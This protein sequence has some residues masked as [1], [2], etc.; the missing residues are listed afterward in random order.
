MTVVALDFETANE[1]R[2]SA[3]AVGL[4]WI[5]DG[6]VVRRASRLIRPP[7]LRF[8]PGNIRVH[9]ILPAD[10]RA[11]PGFGDVMAEFLPD[12]TDGLILAHNASFDIG[13]LRAS[14]AACG[15]A[16]PPLS[17][18]CTLQIA[19]KVF[20]DPGGCGLG[21]V[22]GRLGI[23]FEHHDAGEDAY[24]C[25]EIALAAMRETGAANL[26]ALARTI[27]LSVTRVA[28]QAPRPRAGAITDR[29]L[30]G[31]RPP[32]GPAPLRFTV[33]GSTGSRYEVTVEDRSGTP[34]MRCTCTAGRYGVRCRHVKALVVGDVT[35]LLSGNLGDVEGLRRL[36]AARSGEAVGG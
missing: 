26:P 32:P 16:V 13:V 21:K 3:C 6:R 17:Y 22:A 23:R 36:F 8:A 1:R 34:Q 19:R 14:L 12:L 7:E 30:R 2:D 33:R 28:G 5:A 31:F 15:L 11:Q 24:A 20:P 35:D 25:A 4:A 29:L 18:F 9:G 10:V 27:G